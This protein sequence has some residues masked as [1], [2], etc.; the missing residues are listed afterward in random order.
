MTTDAFCA[1]VS[2]EGGE[3]L[4][5]TASR[6][7]N[8]ILVEYRGLWARNAVDGSALSP[9]VKEHLRARRHARPN[10]KVLFVRRT[11]RRDRTGL[12][13]YWGSTHEHGAQLSRAEI[14]RYDDLLAH[15][16]TTPGDPVEHPLFL[17]CT[18]GKHDR[19]CARHGRPVYQALREQAEPDWVWQ[20]SHVGGDRFAGNVVVLPDGLY[21]GRVEPADV[22]ALVDEQLAGRVLLDRY[23]GR[24]CYTSAQQA[25]ERAV[26]EHASAL[27]VHDVTLLAGEEGLVRF[28]AHGRVYDVEVEQ[29]RGELTYLT[30]NSERLR[31]PRRSVVRSLRESAV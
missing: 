7:D 8:W 12:A 23:R 9:A 26:R 30:C 11:E 28:R 5:A 17:V 24:S 29:T 16:L 3:P 31:P 27:G 21:Y 25:A 4:A 20:C 10:T 15:D 6:V 22:W 19:C 2:R 14:T 1:D 18:H 13:V